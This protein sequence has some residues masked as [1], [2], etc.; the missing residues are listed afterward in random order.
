MQLEQRL[1]ITH[2]SNWEGRLVWSYNIEPMVNMA[3]SQN[4]MEFSIFIL[5][6]PLKML[7]NSNSFLN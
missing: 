5:L 2:I 6:V 3:L 4:Q 7:S 1:F